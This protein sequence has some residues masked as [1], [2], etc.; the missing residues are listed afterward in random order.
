MKYIKELD[1]IRGVG[2]IFVIL[3]HWLPVDSFYNTYPNRPFGVDVFFVLS[4][5]LITHILLTSRLGAEAAGLPMRCVFIDFYWRRALRILPAYFLVVGLIVVSHQRLNATLDAEVL[6]TLT[7]TV[8]YHFYLNRYWGDLTT[9]LWT[10]SVEE[11]FYLL[12]PCVVLLIGRKYLLP[13]I[14][15][16]LGTGILSQLLI[17]D[18]EYGYLPTNTCFDAFGIGAVIAWCRVFRPQEFDRIYHP[19]RILAIMSAVALV[20]AALFPDLFFL[21]PQRTLRSLVAA[22]PISY[23]IY[24]DLRN[25]SQ[26][27]PVF[28][29]GVLRFLGKISYG[30]YLFHIFFP[31]MYDL[32][33]APLIE[34]IPEQF[35]GYSLIII[36]AQN[37]AILVLLSW[38]SYRFIERPIL[39][40]SK[41]RSEELSEAA[42]PQHAVTKK[43]KKLAH[44]FQKFY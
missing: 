14:G 5:F 6:P 34:W 19:V 9:H 32:I 21:S 41:P 12:W 39:A 27:L 16:F 36:V 11:Q 18:M 7:Y 4:G 3:F 25:E 40:W 23:V 31:W 20:V 42:H 10:L 22:W 38:L 13:A 26:N 30:M 8:N 2:I 43:G 33:N 28:S 35:W 24:K 1:S 17:T 29:N 15:I 37:F 44:G